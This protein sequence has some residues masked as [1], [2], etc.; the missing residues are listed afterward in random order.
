MV[1]SY[2]DMMGDPQD[3]SDHPAA[4]MPQATQHYAG[5]VL[6]MP[7]E[8]SMGAG[9]TTQAVDYATGKAKDP[10]VLP[11][12]NKTLGDWAKRKQ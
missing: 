8:R 1:N 4:N 5:D 10:K 2:D 3:P 12:G 6:P 11:I 7:G 9:A